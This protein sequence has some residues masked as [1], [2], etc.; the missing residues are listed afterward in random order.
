MASSPWPGLSD[1]QWASWSTTGTLEPTRSTETRTFG[2]YPTQMFTPEPTGYT[3]GEAAE[4]PPQNP[5]PTEPVP[6]TEPTADPRLPPPRSRSSSVE[7]PVPAYDTR[8]PPLEVPE[9]YVNEPA[10]ADAYDTWAQNN[11]IPAADVSRE[12][13]NSYMET[14]GNLPNWHLT[15]EGDAMFNRTTAEALGAPYRGTYLSQMG[16]GTGAG[17][18]YIPPG[19]GEAL[20]GMTPLDKKAEVADYYQN[21]GVADL[22]TAEA[23]NASAKTASRRFK[24]FLKSRN[25]RRPISLSTTESALACSL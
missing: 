21:L 9:G 3:F 8:F 14:Y 1:E 13:F 12:S 4:Q 24:T 19:F 7:P 22:M 25:P 10:S 5:W 11:P 18:A 2:S 23:G 16:T 6:T 15:P 17:S 20:E